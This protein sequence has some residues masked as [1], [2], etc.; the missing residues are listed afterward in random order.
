MI[1]YVLKFSACLLI[2]Q[3][4]YKLFLEKE[5]IHRLKR[6]YL[7]LAIFAAVIIPSIT[8]TT[9]VEQPLVSVS[10]MVL[11]S[12]GDMIV[13]TDRFLSILVM[14]A[15]IVYGMGVIIFGCKFLVNLFSIRSKI[16]NNPKQYQKGFTNVLLQKLTVPHTFFSYIFLDKTKYENNEIPEAVHLHEQA[17]AKQQ[18]S[19]DILFIELLQIVLWFNPLIYFLKKDIKLNHEY[20]ADAAVINQGISLS[21]YQEIVLAFSAFEHKTELAHAFNYSSI[22]KRLTIMKTKTSK[23]RAWIRSLLLLPLLAIL[24]YG[25]SQEKVITEKTSLQKSNDI[26]EL[27]KE[28]ETYHMLSKHYTDA[29]SQWLKSERGDN[30][31]LKALKLKADEVYSIISEEKKEKY[32]LKMTPPIPAENS[33]IKL[34]EGATKAEMAEYNKLARKY[35]YVKK[36]T[37][38]KIL[39]KDFEKM[40]YIYGKMTKAQRESAEPFPNI[41]LPPPPPPPAENATKEQLIKYEKA[42]LEYKHRLGKA[43]LRQVS[44]T[45]IRVK[46][47]PPKPPK[48]ATAAEMKKYEK[49]LKEYKEQASKAYK[50]RTKATPVEIEVVEVPPPPPPPIPPDATDEERRRY[51]KIIAEYAKKYPNSV[52]KYRTK[53]GKEVETVEVPVEVLEVPPPPPPKSIEELAKEGAEFYFEGKKISAKEALEVV[54]KKSPTHIEYK[55]LNGKK[56]VHISMKPKKKRVKQ[57]ANNSKTNNQKAGL[58]NECC[59]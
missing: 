59:K 34:Q 5:S 45:K 25:F 7:L 33:K 55:N 15:W 8:F 51:K 21:L 31:E 9:V 13:E 57:Q 18:H 30:S 24:V 49:V 40:K 22:K 50:K 54:E 52:S 27:D 53:S 20:L 3:V 39:E 44:P 23:Q 1:V 42:L 6:Y 17:H 28:V 16:V 29:L 12:E 10:E 48:N 2:L 46:E 47:Q 43:K 36:G 19:L 37:T 14:V 11:I 56:T 35:N 58:N 32:D 26:I 41:P 4:F 38:I